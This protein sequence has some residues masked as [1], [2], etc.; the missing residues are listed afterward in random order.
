MLDDL[1]KTAEPESLTVKPVLVWAE[2]DGQT[3]VSELTAQP[4]ARHE[5][6]DV[7]SDD[8]EIE[9]AVRAAGY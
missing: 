5:I 8:F 7:L 3:C 2:N 4:R 1:H 9:S 6:W